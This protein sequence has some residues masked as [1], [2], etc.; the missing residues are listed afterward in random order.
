M[1]T[2]PVPVSPQ[3]TPKPRRSRQSARALSHGLPEGGLAVAEQPVD[4]L[5]GGPEPQGAACVLLCDLRG[6]EGHIAV[7]GAMA[8]QELLPGEPAGRGIGRVEGQPVEAVLVLV[9]SLG[10]P[11]PVPR[12]IAERVD[13]AVGGERLRLPVAEGLSADW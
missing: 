3:D 13:R 12:V 8:D 7:P 4:D 11:E 2:G 10:R 6:V 9:E 5:V 1:I